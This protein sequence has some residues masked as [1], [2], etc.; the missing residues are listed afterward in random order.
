VLIRLR[1]RGIIEP[2]VRKQGLPIRVAITVAAVVCAL[3]IPAAAGAAPPV[4]ISVGQQNRHPT[5]TFSAPGAD[6]ATIYLASKPDRAT[7]GR[8]LEENV[9]RVDFLTDDEIQ[10]GVW[11]DS[12]QIDPRVYYVMLRADDFDCEAPNCTEGFS[13]V[14]TLRIP[15]PRPTYRGSVVA[16]FRYSGV[17]MLQFTATPLGERLPYRVCWRL[18]SRKRRCV[19]SAVRGY[20][21]NSSASDTV[22]VRMRGMAR[23]T[24]FTWHVGGRAV[25]AKTVN[26]ARGN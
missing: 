20:S 16:I 17:V 24:T 14:M 12:E 18:K 11:L 22:S 25:S 3:A 6:I 21:W 4:L 13:S 8:F 19:S 9:E 7:D 15:K 23:R 10:R 1:L 5:A 2:A 26:T